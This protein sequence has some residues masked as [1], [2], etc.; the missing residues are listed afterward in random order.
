MI[1]IKMRYV[2]LAIDTI[3]ASLLQNLNIKIVGEMTAPKFWKHIIGIMYN[4]M[5]LMVNHNTSMQL[6][7]LFNLITVFKHRHMIFMS[8]WLNMDVCVFADKFTI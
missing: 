7:L 5:D 3:K 4:W 1:V 6:L 8:I 2:V